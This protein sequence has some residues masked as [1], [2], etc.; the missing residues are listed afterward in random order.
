MTLPP[1]EPVPAFG[2]EIQRN[3]AFGEVTVNPG[4]DDRPFDRKLFLDFY[5]PIRE[6]RA[7]GRTGDLPAVIYVHGGAFHRGGRFQPP[8]KESGVIHSRPEDYARL[9][10]PLGY[11]VFVVEYRLAT[12]NPEPAGQPG[13]PG[14][15]PV[16][17]FVSDAM[18]AATDR[19]RASMGLPP[20]KGDEGR[21]FMWKA[22][23]TAAEDVKMA[24]DFV[25]DNADTFNIDADRI[26]M[27][28]H[29]AGGLTTLHVAYGLRGKLR[30]IFPMSGGEVAYT[31]DHVLESEKVPAT[32]FT[33]SQ[34]DWDAIL[35]G[36]PSIVQLMKK[37][38]IPYEL[39]WIPSPGHFYPYNS[40][41]MGSNGTVVA[42]GD[43]VIAFLQEHLRLQN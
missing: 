11:G 29:S 15:K 40:P 42:L 1:F 16:N 20:L 27:G 30:A 19:A 3:V 4:E 9:L 6:R 24:L 31:D 36:V 38:G 34:N 22:A 5:R 10:A 43:R 8:F 21:L 28:G 25:I 26:A 12:D 33:V 32:L 18:L 41:S 2:Y 35:E 13:D 37:A 39:N 17:E 23:I 7:R 14:L